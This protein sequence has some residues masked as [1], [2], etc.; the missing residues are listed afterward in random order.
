MEEKNKPHDDNSP[1]AEQ[2][3]ESELGTSTVPE[4]PQSV[5]HHS[6]PDQKPQNY[7]EELKARA[8]VVGLFIA[9]FGAVASAF[10]ACGAWAVLDANIKRDQVDQRAWV[11]I[12]EMEDPEIKEG[13]PITF[14]VTAKNF[15]KTPAKKVV[16]TIMAGSLPLGEP[17]VPQYPVA[18]DTF[19]HEGGV[20]VVYPSMEVPLQSKPV[21]PMKEEGIAALRDSRIVMYI[22]GKISYEDVFR[23][24]H[25]T[26]FC[27]FMHPTLQRVSQCK[28]YN[29]AD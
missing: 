22:W 24:E 13:P 21:G 4:T 14:K 15:G 23:I 20:G 3:V 12:I 25:H 9:A 29:D 1:T 2:H 17:F 7:W 18:L 26:T 11:G 6:G 8:P 16:S 5:T 28:T 19:P 27:L 10:S